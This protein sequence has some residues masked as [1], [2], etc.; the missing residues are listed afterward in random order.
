MSSARPRPCAFRKIRFGGGEKVFMND[1]VKYEGEDRVVSSHEVRDEIGSY[2]IVPRINSGIPTLDKLCDGFMAGEMVV[3]TGQTKMGKTSLARTLTE[4]FLEQEHQCLWFSYEE[5]YQQFLS[6]FD[7]LPL[8]YLPRQLT[9]SSPE[10]I[11]ERIAEAKAKYDIKAVFVDHLGYLIDVFKLRNA[12]LEIGTIVRQIRSL[13]L[14]YNLVLF[15]LHHVR[16]IDS[17]KE[18]TYQDLR[19]SELIAGEASAVLVI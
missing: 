6:S 17:K 2:V 7:P 12:S 4:R 9:K 11:E 14:K 8:F 15:L 16:R 10:W 19:D 13:A 1:P 5:P 3:I 18:P